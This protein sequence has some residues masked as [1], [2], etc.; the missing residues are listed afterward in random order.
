MATVR[1]D[2]PIACSLEA[3][4][5]GER[6]ARW[7]RLMARASLGGSPTAEGVR[8]ELRAEPGVPEEVDALLRLEREC[9]GFAAWS[10][11]PEG[12][13]VV[14]EVAADGI[15]ATVVRQMFGLDLP[16]GREEPG[17]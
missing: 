6:A 8:F 2:E 15:G 11:R 17:G 13:R 4:E 3:T 1:A 5:L 7:A 9:C 16:G 14:V 12:H 10:M